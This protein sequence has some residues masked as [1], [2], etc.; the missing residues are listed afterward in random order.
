MNCELK[1]KVEKEEIRL[2][3]ISKFEAFIHADNIINSTNENLSISITESI[4]V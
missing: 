1:I 3:D 2:K 4:L